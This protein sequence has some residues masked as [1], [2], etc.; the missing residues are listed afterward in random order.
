MTDPLI[1]LLHLDLSSA[2]T[3]PPF[4][5]LLLYTPPQF[6]LKIQVVAL[7][8]ARLQAVLL[9]ISFPAVSATRYLPY[10][11]LSLEQRRFARHF[12]HFV[13]KCITDC[14]ASPHH[15]HLADSAAP[16]RSRKVPIA[17]F[18]TFN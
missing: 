10:V 3:S 7:L 6:P 14:S 1:G 8:H 17:P 5:L 4:V 18:P 13:Y 2:S 9:A 16:I 12:R 11:D 15:Q